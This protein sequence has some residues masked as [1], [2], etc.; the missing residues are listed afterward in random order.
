MDKGAS[1]ALPPQLADE[2]KLSWSHRRDSLVASAA[3]LVSLLQIFLFAP[4]LQ[5]TNHILNVEFLVT[6]FRQIASS[7]SVPHF[8]YTSGLSLI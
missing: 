8:R 2:T 6:M 5:Y 4:G 3:I 7:P 1:A